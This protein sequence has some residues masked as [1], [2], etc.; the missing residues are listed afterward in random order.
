[1]AGKATAAR[2]GDPVVAHLKALRVAMF[3]IAV[4]LVGFTLWV[5][6]RILE[7]F[8]LSLFLLIMIDGLARA[9]DRRIP[10]YPRAAA[11]PTAIVS[12]LAVFGLTLWL[13]IDN[14][15]A[16]AAQAPVYTQRI[17]ALLV[18]GAGTLGLAV[19]P[20]VTDLIREI[21]PA[22]YAGVVAGHLS[23]FA[24]AAVFMFIYLG[25][26]LA[27]RRGFAA[28]AQGFFP[29]AAERQEAG[30]VF[31]RVRH[32]VESYVWVQTVVGLIITAL[33]AALMLATGLSHVGFWCAIIFLSNYIPAIGAAI[34]V[35]FPA[36]FGLV[37]FTALWPALILIGGL[38]AI[39]F[40]VSH[41]VQPRLQSRSL[42]LDPIVV[43]LALA[44][45]GAVWGV[46]GA[47]LSTPLAV[48]AMAIMAEFKSTRP[49]AVLLSRDGKPY[50]DL[51]AESRP[52]K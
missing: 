13:T 16:F 45:W 29:D 25:F 50:A 43:L 12:I 27:S 9:I 17:N 39:H 42:N 34:G 49:L 33:S 41:V 11:M 21:N 19:T 1:M 26:L 10:A 47:F 44:F 48:V 15:T 32:G 38:E 52:G 20:T 23:H 31:E 37:E 2:S 24:E 6:R 3:V 18:S 51:E 40:G 36:V 4:I 14:A 35:L 7:P 46:V 22:R 8:V 28:K 5:L 30:K